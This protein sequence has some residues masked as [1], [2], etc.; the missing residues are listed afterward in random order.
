[1]ICS[2]DDSPLDANQIF[3]FLSLLSLGTYITI[4]VVV[5]LQLV[6]ILFSF[7]RVSDF[8]SYNHFSIPVSSSRNADP[9]RCNSRRIVHIQRW[10]WYSQDRIRHFEDCWSGTQIWC[11][12]ISSWSCVWDAS[13]FCT[14]Y[15]ERSWT[16][17][18]L[19]INLLNWLLLTWDRCNLYCIGMGAMISRV[20]LEKAG[21]SSSLDLINIDWLKGMKS[22]TVYS[23]LLSPG[24]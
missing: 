2:T 17:L 24:G 3:H 14:W 8:P 12:T 9:L 18:M 21:P 4:R 20:L 1:M 23:M 16:I 11:I 5:L 6:I 15:L 7:D 10:K 22:K 13:R 19:S